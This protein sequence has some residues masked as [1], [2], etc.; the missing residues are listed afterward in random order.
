MPVPLRDTALATVN[1]GDGAV[2]RQVCRVGA[3]AHGA[4]Q[5]A[6]GAA[7]LHRI[8]DG[9]LRQQTDH[10]VLAGAEFRGA[11]ALQP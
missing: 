5:I 10:R 3:Q 8:A 6:V 2:R 11:G 9:P 7:L 1:R 4:A